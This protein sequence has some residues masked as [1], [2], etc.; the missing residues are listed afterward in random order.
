[1]AL[2]FSKKIKRM[3][4][5]IKKEHGLVDE[6]LEPLLVPLSLKTEATQET[7]LVFFNKWLRA[8]GQFDEHTFLKVLREVSD[9]SRATAYYALSFIYRSYGFEVPYKHSEVVPKSVRK[10]KEIMSPEFYLNYMG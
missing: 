7:Y 4:E 5:N 9:N 2:R 10:H 1:M 6:N 8:G 3:I